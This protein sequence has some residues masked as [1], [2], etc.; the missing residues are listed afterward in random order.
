MS[1]ECV[2]Q[3]LVN[4]FEILIGND[5]EKLFDKSGDIHSIVYHRNEKH[6]LMNGYST[7]SYE[8]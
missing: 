3:L 6:F 5:K 4:V 1:I 7:D 8:N 2:R